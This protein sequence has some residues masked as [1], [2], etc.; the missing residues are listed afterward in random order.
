[1]AIPLKRP[2]PADVTSRPE[3]PEHPRPW[4]PAHIGDRDTA[5]AA[6][7]PIVVTSADLDQ[8]LD[9]FLP[10]PSDVHGTVPGS[11]PDA[12]DALEAFSSERETGAQPAREATMLSATSPTVR[13]PVR[14]AWGRRHRIASDR[15]VTGAVLVAVVSASS[16][17]GFVWLQRSAARVDLDP[18]RA[19]ATA[20][21]IQTPTIEHPALVLARATVTRTTALSRALT[22]VSPAAV[23]E[24]PL[25]REEPATVPGAREA[26]RRDPVTSPLD[27]RTIVNPTGSTETTRSSP[28]PPAAP[29]LAAADSR[30]ASITV[31]ESPVVP[32]H[33]APPPPNPGTPEPRNLGTP[34]PANPGTSE[35]RNLGTSE[36]TETAAIQSVL[37]RYRSAFNGLDAGAAS[38][39]WPTVDQRA[40]GRAFDQLDEQTVAFSNCTVVVSGVRA[41]ASCGGTAHYVPK[42]GNKNPLT[43][44]RHWTFDLRK[45]ND[46]WVI[47][48]VRTK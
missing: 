19:A 47:D 39:V 6:A 44:S 32:S 20:P 23:P 35:P 28:G 17:M 25:T 16:F 33:V 26:E 45:V 9:E 10:E 42:V 11:R 14:A 40:L 48:A 2:D 46:A 34:G 18:P 38:R 29:L 41:T 22:A 37:G 5:W 30:A 24:E 3:L 21:V 15:L 43:Q 27:A 12:D 31:D 4:R 8:V 7:D 13:V 1:M 36:A